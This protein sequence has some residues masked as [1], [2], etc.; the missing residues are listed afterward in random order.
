MPTGL[1]RGGIVPPKKGERRGGRQKGAPNKRSLEVTERL[2]KFK[3]DPLVALI[4]VARGKAKRPPEVYFVL[5]KFIERLR[6]D[7]VVY[8]AEEVSRV[9]QIVEEELSGFVPQ[10]RVIRVNEALMEYRYP[11][12]KALEV[13]QVEPTRVEIVTMDH[14]PSCG[15]DLTRD[16]PDAGVLIPALTPQPGEEGA[17]N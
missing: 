7:E 16:D 15:F 9:R 13:E 6:L 17:L 10:D 14:C 2:E 11:R 4:E 12:L 1:R 3:H 8:T 5:R